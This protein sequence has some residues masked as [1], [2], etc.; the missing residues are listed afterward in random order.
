VQAGGV[1]GQAVQRHLHLQ[2]AVVRRHYRVAEAGGN[3][4]L[5]LGQA[6]AE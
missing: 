6:V 5:G 1:G 4:Q 3:Q 2:A